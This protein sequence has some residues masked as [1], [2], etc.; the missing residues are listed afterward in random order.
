MSNEIGIFPLTK[1]LDPF[2]GK[3]I[4]KNSNFSILPIFLYFHQKCKKSA[5]LTLKTL[6]MAHM[7]LKV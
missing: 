6:K 1:A 2:N 3:K 4:E 5:K 7:C